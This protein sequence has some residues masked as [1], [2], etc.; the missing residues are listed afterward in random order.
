MVPCLVG[1]PVALQKR[2]DVLGGLGAELRYLTAGCLWVTPSWQMAQQVLFWL[3]WAVTW[4][5]HQVR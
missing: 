4:N 1:A 5:E 3:G 2:A